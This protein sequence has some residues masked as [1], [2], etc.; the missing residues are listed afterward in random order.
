MRYRNLGSTGTI[1]STLCLGTMTFGAE[2]DEATA[3]RQLDTYVE[4]GGTFVD[5]ADIYSHGT[6]ESVIGRWI[7]RRG[8]ADDLVVATKARMPMGP[9]HNDAGLSRPHLQRAVDASLSR[10]GVEV[11]DLYQAHLWDPRTPLEETL[12]TFDD[13]VRGGKIRY[14]GVSNFTGWQLQRA[15]LLA[16]ERGWAPVVTLQPQYSL[17]ARGVEWELLPL[18]RH[19]GIGVLPW[20]PLG[21][22]WLT[23]K[24]SREE[25]PQ[26][27]TRLGEDPGRGQEAYDRRNTERT[28]DVVDAVRAVADA[29]GVTPAQVALAWVTDR[30]AVSSTILGART[31]DQLDGNLAAADLVLSEEETSRLDAVSDPGLPA[32]PYGFIAE[33]SRR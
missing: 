4:A 28:W 32:Y 19:D 14:V 7:T 30:P 17:L 18:C 1:V 27:A 33:E 5:T 21:G 26:G 9:G 6:S 24:Y 29:R 25:R 15:S 2:T 31:V 3:H 10:L 13:L 16:R 23:G 22:G 8:G 12:S 20:S 11:I